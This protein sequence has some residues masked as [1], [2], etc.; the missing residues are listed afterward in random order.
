MVSSS[1][2][3]LF[4]TVISV[5][6]IYIVFSIFNKVYQE[7]Y[8]KPWLYIGISALFLAV[9]Q[10]LD[11][12]SGYYNHYIINFNINEFIIL[13]LQFISMTILTYGL[14]LELLILKYYKG[15]FVKLK[16]VPVQEGTIDSNLDISVFAGNSYIAIKKEKNFLLEQF[17]KATKSGFEGFLITETNP[18]E[19]REKYNLKKTP[20]AWIYKNE[21]ETS[22][23]TIKEFLDEN[24]DV[25]EPID[26]NNILFFIDNFL[27]ISQTP[28]VFLDLNQILK[29]NNFQI[30]VEFLKYVSG[31]VQKY[32]GILLLLVNTDVLEKEN[33]IELISFLKELE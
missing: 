32:N 17:S 28:F 11:F 19:I 1:I 26:L 2:I 14:V 4:S 33:K 31:K 22:T 21:T 3:S 30:V 20:I 10:L 23:N 8:K 12:I 7:A 15:K 27:E 13:S 18:K 24:S 25:V 16:F 6:G 29:I 9:S 5:I